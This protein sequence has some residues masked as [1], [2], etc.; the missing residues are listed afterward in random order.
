MHQEREFPGR[1]VATSLRNPDFAAYARS[2]GLDGQVVTATDAFP[3]AFEQAL[4][5][6]TAALIELRLQ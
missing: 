5:Q 1:V 2:F 6:S 4:A 3:A